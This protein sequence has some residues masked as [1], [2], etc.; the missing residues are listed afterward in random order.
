MGVPMSSKY[1]Q[2]ELMLRDGM[3]PTY[4]MGHMLP[5]ISMRALQILHTAYLREKNAKQS[6]FMETRIYI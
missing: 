4:I 5:G 2:L 3:D 1:A 6:G